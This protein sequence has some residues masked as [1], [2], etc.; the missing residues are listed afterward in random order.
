MIWC[1]S[2][3]LSIH[4]IP[5]IFCN[6]LQTVKKKNWKI[7]MFISTILIWI[8]CHWWLLLW[9]NTLHYVTQKHE[10]LLRREKRIR[11]DLMIH[12]LIISDSF[13]A[14]KES[15][16]SSSWYVA[17]QSSCYFKSSVLHGINYFLFCTYLVY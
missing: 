7:K 8:T 16:A 5:Q 12:Y 1:I 11:S 2:C 17:N 15:S 3:S 6:I 4:Q 14:P 10:K 13:W 9:I